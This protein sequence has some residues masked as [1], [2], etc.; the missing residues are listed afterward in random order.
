MPLREFA[1]TP[2]DSHRA[3]TGS[4]LDWVAPEYST[5]EVLLAASYRKLLLGKRDA[6][7][8][9]EDIHALPRRLVEVM[10]EIPATTWAAVLG[11]RG[12]IR[13]PSLR[14]QKGSVPLP[15]L[16]PLVPEV[17]RYAGV[18]GRKRSRWDPGKLL[19]HAMATGRG[20][21]GSVEL[22]RNFGSALA[23]ASI[24]EDV[25]AQ[26]LE[27]ALRRLDSANPPA[28]TPAIEPM[29]APFRGTTVT[30]GGL[31]PAERFGADLLALMECKS[32]LTRRQW[33]ALVE[34]LLRVGLGTH[35]LWMFR[36]NWAVWEQA[37]RALD[38]QEVPDVEALASAAWE[39]HRTGDPFL[40][41]GQDAT[42]SIRRQIER[43]VHA[44]VGL[45]M[46]L[47]ALEDVDVPVTS[48]GS[49]AEGAPA[50]GALREFLFLVRRSR[51]RLAADPG[52]WARR[53]CSRILDRVPK[54]LAGKA[55]FAKNLYEFLRYS[56]GQ[57]QPGVP[58]ERAYDQSYVLRKRGT[59]S[60]SPWVVELGP[61]AQVLL[62]HLCCRANGGLPA[63]IED[64]RLHL[65][66]Y[67]I[68]APAQELSEGKLAR[69]MEHLGLVIDSPDAA[70]G[71]IL[72]DPLAGGA[73]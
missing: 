61:A 70:G 65:S 32:R 34:G 6:E 53:E 55:S 64:F 12:G 9:L 26:F 27:A 72:V 41:H 69:D 13:S 20:A 23:V 50:V 35:V 31:C 25:F 37:L 28:P 71:R 29:A 58:E 3:Y 44:R 45:N 19:L 22:A 73:Q 51:G 33:I 54:I 7:V 40:E 43:Y 1:E 2:T 57:I 38:D 42:P 4:V 68:A 52:Q 39:G 63:S 59:A 60:S 16:M 24:D 46:L 21:A 47:H 66:D 8:D 36:L 67:G 5:G 18:L 10:P 30:G 56:L 11:S 14:G 49:V 15:Q 17:A 48:I 62:V